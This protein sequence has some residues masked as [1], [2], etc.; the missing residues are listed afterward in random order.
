MT[1]KDEV[2]EST[3]FLAQECEE[4]KRDIMR[5]VCLRLHSPLL[6]LEGEN[7]NKLR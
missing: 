6:S 7:V 1:Q 4:K 5:H 3:F 2:K